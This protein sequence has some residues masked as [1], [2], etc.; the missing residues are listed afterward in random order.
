LRIRASCAAL[1]AMG[2]KEY[3]EFRKPPKQLAEWT[4]LLASNAAHLARILKPSPYPGN[5]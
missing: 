3:K 5:G 4:P 2:S 1:E